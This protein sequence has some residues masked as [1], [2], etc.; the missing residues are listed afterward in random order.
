MELYEL[1]AST[2]FL[3]KTSD[4]TWEIMEQRKQLK[5]GPLDKIAY[6]SLSKNIQNKM[7][8]R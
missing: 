6:E 5:I 3:S 2:M 7:P 8:Q 4:E 1:H